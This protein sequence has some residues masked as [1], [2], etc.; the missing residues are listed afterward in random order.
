MT[1]SPMSRSIA[2]V[3]GEPAG[4]GMLVTEVLSSKLER[5]I[6]FEGHRYLDVGC[7]NGSFTVNLGRRFDQVYGIDVE[8]GRVR[9]FKRKVDGQADR[10]ALLALMSA[11]RTGFPTGFFDVITAIEVFEHIPDLERAAAELARILKPRG[12][13]GLTCPN[14]LFPFET[15]GVRWRGREIWGRFPLLPYLPALHRRFALARVFTV[16]D[17]DRLLVKHG[18]VRIG[19]DYAYPTFERGNRLGRLMRPF[20]TVMRLGEESPL[21]IFGVSIVAAYQ[22]R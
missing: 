22:V 11:E 13:L 12:F 9:S 2:P 17:L 14:R 7:G 5:L 18:F 16:A 4:E 1:L 20:R 10:R 6:R 21:K 8:P 19:L 15:H 3:L